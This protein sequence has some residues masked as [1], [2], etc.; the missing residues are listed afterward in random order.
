MASPNQWTCVWAN[1]RRHWRTGKPG[2]LQSMGLQRVRHDLVPEQ[3]TGYWKKRENLFLQFC[4]VLFFKPNQLVRKGKVLY[5]QINCMFSF[6]TWKWSKSISD[7]FQLIA[8]PWAVAHQAP[9]SKVFSRPE[10]W[11]GLLFPSARDLP[12]LG[13]EPGSPILQA[14]SLPFEPLGK[15][16]LR[17]SV[18]GKGDGE[19]SEGPEDSCHFVESHHSF[20]WIL[21]SLPRKKRQEQFLTFEWGQLD[22]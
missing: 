17:P 18:K 8:T 19:K 2:V 16:I 11:G 20:M 21:G 4:F 15:P 12:H 6:H 7:C 22:R 10:Y 13:I 5:I 3:Q 9:L 14:D 1:S